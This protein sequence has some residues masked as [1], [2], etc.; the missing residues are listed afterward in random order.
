MKTLQRDV[1]LARKLA[2]T[3]GALLNTAT[4][5]LDP[6]LE[7]HDKDGLFKMHEDQLLD[8]ISFIRE[9]RRRV[10]PIELKGQRL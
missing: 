10:N 7:M 3:G 6:E 5:L 4:N 1:N 2:K 8:C 9:Y